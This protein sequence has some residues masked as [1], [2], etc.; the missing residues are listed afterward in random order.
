M[1]EP[2]TTLPTFPIPKTVEEC[3]AGRAKVIE[4]IQYASGNLNPDECQFDEAASRLRNLL[5]EEYWI[6]ASE[7]NP[8]SVQHTSWHDRATHVGLAA[9][10]VQA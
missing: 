4:Y 9:K 6:V 2:I 1:S 5:F 3:R 8:D 10:L 7:L